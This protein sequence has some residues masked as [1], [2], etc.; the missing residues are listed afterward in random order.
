MKIYLIVDDCP[1]DFG[2]HGLF[3][4]AFVSKTKAEEFI[5]EYKKK[6]EYKYQYLTTMIVNV[7]DIISHKT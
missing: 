7:V 3:T 2:A 1:D 4:E 6:D 5:R